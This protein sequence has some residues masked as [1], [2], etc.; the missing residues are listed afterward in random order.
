M[1]DKINIADIKSV[2]K[3]FEIIRKTDENSLDSHDAYVSLSD[4]RNLHAIP[5]KSIQTSVKKRLNNASFKN[6]LIGQRLKRMPS[7]I[8]KIIRL[9]DM[10]ESR[11]QD[12]GGLRIIVPSIDDVNKVHSII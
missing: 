11:M 1:S 10:S 6:Y 8:G 9:P 3:Y 7:I 2:Q 12:V 4:W 5:L